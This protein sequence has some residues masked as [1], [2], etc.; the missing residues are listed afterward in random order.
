MSLDRK[1]KSIGK[2]TAPRQV[3]LEGL[4]RGYTEANIRTLGGY[5]S[6]ELVEAGIRIEA[7]KILLD[8]GHGRPSQQHKHVGTAPDGSFQFEVRLIHEGKPKG[9]K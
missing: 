1:K 4:A 2:E 9:V 3:D 6:N 8:R 5:A 7:I